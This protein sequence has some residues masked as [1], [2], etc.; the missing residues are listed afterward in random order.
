M[1]YVTNSPEELKKQTSQEGYKEDIPVYVL[2]RWVYD[3]AVSKFNLLEIHQYKNLRSI[4]SVSDLAQLE[5]IRM[6]LFDKCL[7]N[8]GQPVMYSLQ[9]FVHNVGNF[10]GKLVMTAEEQQEVK[11]TVF[12]L[13]ESK[14]LQE[15]TFSRLKTLEDL[16]PKGSHSDDVVSGPCSF[17][18]KEQLDKKVP[19]SIT[20]LEGSLYII[21]E[22]GF[23]SHLEKAAEKL[24]FFTHVLK[25]AYAVASITDVNRTVWYRQYLLALAGK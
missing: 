24:V 1:S 3:A 8:K 17:P 16:N 21:V 11:N 15:E 25:S 19:Y 10:P 4:L 18:T 5:I 2:P 20:C 23:L 22:E 14:A 13:M 7:S 12:P 6:Y 9:S